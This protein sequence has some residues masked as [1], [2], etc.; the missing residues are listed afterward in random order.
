MAELKV[1]EPVE[2]SFCLDSFYG[3]DTHLDRCY[4]YFWKP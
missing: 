1:A 2:A 3:T 4:D